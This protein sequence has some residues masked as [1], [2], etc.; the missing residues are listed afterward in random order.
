MDYSK[1]FILVDANN[2]QQKN[3]PVLS[4]RTNQKTE[5]NEEFQKD[6]L[7]KPA[8][9][10]V[11]ELDSQMNQILENKNL[12]TWE[13]VSQYNQILGQFQE[14]YKRLMETPVSV[15]MEVP[16]SQEVP[17]AQNLHSADEPVQ[18][19]KKDFSILE[20]LKPALRKRGEQ[21]LDILNKSS[22]VGFTPA[23]ELEVDG[24]TVT[25]S[26]AEQLLSTLL[27]SKTAKKRYEPIGWS[28]MIDAL[29]KL[30]IPE[31][32]IPWLK[33]SS[34]SSQSTP[35]LKKVI[36]Q[37]A[38]NKTDLTRKILKGWSPY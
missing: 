14:R 19:T 4:N 21:L 31:A 25:N 29:K 32:L 38:S 11:L 6:R 30:D 27:Q 26:N 33:Q 7:M 9:K 16:K 24:K 28:S 35:H 5:L 34:S 37:R 15:K 17:T 13:K 22:S 12:S 8:V 3:A 1:K 10:E 18:T 36:R 20:N 2:L 23:G